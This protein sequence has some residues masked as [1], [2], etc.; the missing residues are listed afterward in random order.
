MMPLHV[1]LAGA[2]KAPP[3]GHHAEF[4]AR[5]PGTATTGYTDGNDSW[6]R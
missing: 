1:K 3:A 4:G 6:N 5:P 2:P